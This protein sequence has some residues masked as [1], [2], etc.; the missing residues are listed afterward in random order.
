MKYG[1]IPHVYDP[2]IPIDNEILSEMD[3]MVKTAFP[4]EKIRGVS[5]RKGIEGANQILAPESCY[6]H[7][8]IL[9]KD[10]TFSD[11]RNGKSGVKIGVECVTINLTLEQYQGGVTQYVLSMYTNG[12]CHFPRKHRKKEMRESH[13]LD[14]PYVRDYDT[15][16][17]AF[18]QTLEDFVKEVWK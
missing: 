11:P 17:E 1:D 8:Y 4:P 7:V 13:Y 9:C 3:A 12:Y 5:F 2:D 6:W 16:I 15:D 14:W 10:I 18:R